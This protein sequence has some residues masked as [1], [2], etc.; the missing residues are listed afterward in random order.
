MSDFKNAVAAAETFVNGLFAVHA[1]PYL[2]FHNLH[3][4]QAVVKRVEEMLGY[5]KLQQRPAAAVRI[6]AWFHDTGYL[7]G[8]PVCHEVRGAHFAKLFLIDHG[9]FEDCFQ[10]IQGCIMATQLPQ[11]PAS[12]LQQILCDADLFHLGKPDFFECDA[13]MRKETEFRFSG[14]ISDH[15][16]QVQTMQLL[17]E[18]R[19]HTAYCQQHLEKQKAINLAKL[20][21]LLDQQ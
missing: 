1:D 8:G 10:D 19:Y 21:S 5:Y 3:H 4:T 9:L 18:H 11:Q 20:E 6:A 14:P 15:Q 13:L 7:N 2:V 12:L 17:K 16:W